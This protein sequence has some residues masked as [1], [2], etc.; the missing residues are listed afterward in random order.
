MVV[1]P[2]RSGYLSSNLFIIN[3]ILI[4]VDLRQNLFFK[5][6][7]KNVDSANYNG[8]ILPEP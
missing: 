1:S 5:K 4:S 3:L 6:F 8:I 2:A 7:L